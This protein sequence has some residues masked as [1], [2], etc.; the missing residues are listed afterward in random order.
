[1]EI[2]TVDKN[3]PFDI[4]H[5]HTSTINDHRL[6]SALLYCTRVKEGFDVFVRLV[7]YEVNAAARFIPRSISFKQ[8]LSAQQSREEAEWVA[9]SI[10]DER[11]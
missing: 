3:F 8:R 5:K 10:R 9:H 11:L 2:S 7:S 4:L 6:P 1:M